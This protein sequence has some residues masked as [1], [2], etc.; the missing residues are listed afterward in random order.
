M[1]NIISK[2]LFISVIALIAVTSCEKDLTRVVKKSYPT[3]QDR[4]VLYYDGEPSKETWVK[5][6]LFHENGQL[7]TVKRYEKGIQNGWTESYYD[8]GAPMAKVMYKD[9][10]KIGHYWKKHRNGKISY[11]GDYKEDRRNGDWIKLDE[12]GDT[13]R[14]ETY[15]LGKLVGGK[16][17]DKNKK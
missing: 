2:I 17:F 14:I 13:I 6:E 9:G 16:K 15:E 12:N 3:G 10:R 4:F 11:T 8:N 5:A 7:M 1:K